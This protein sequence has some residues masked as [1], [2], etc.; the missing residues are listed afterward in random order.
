MGPRLYT[1][2][3]VPSRPLLLTVP[4]EGVQHVSMLLDLP[5]EDVDVGTCVFL[6]AHGSGAPMTSSFIGGVA[7]RLA[8]LGLPV[9]RFQYAYMEQI[10]R[11]GTRRPPDRRSLL[12]AVHLA[13]LRDVQQRFPGRHVLSGG[14]SLGGR[15]AS[16]LAAAGEA[17]A[18][19]ILL[20]YPLHPAGKPDQLRSEHFAALA[21]PALFVQGDRDSLCDLALLRRALEVYGGQATLAVI[22]GADHGF[23]VLRS[24]G[25]STGQVLD[26]V[27][28]RTIAWVRSTF[29]A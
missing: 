17:C 10:Q 19:L 14:K 26:D 11:S 18:G 8:A 2:S 25:R 28:A 1:L 16:Y 5:A 7:E 29:S 27:A 13:A 15:I 23:D 6:L 3:G 4:H 12:E 20:G 21:Q 22:E 9:L 24:S